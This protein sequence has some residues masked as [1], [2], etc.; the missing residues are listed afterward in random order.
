MYECRDYSIL[1]VLACCYVSG[2]NVLVSAFL[3]GAFL[4]YEFS[5]LLDISPDLQ[6]ITISKPETT[7]IAIKKHTWSYALLRNINTG[8]ETRFNGLPGN[9]ETRVN[10]I[11]SN[12]LMFYLWRIQCS[13]QRL[14]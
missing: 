12:H 4:Q 14:F 10:L 6:L 2:H 13:Y 5:S 9:E 3:P 7:Y 8:E 11:Y 1:I